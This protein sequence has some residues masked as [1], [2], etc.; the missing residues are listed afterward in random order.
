MTRISAID[1]N[2]DMGESFGNWVMGR[3]EEMFPLITT[4]NIACGFHAGD[5]TVMRRTVRMAKQ[6]GVAVGAHPGYHDLEGFGRRRIQLGPDEVGA[7]L[8]YQIGALRAFLDTEGMPLHHVKPHG[9]LYS[10]LRDD[11]A[12]GLAGA[13][14]I[15]A[16]LPGVM[17]YWPAPAFGTVFCDELRQLGHPVVGDL[18]PD[19]SYD[20]NGTLV[21]K[22]KIT[23]TDMDFAL[24]QVRQFLKSGQVHTEAGTLVDMTAGSIC[25]HG[26]GD[27]AVELAAAV[28]QTVVDAGVA[29]Q[30]VSA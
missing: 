21:I 19:L 5:P 11:E 25:V 28:R 22:R 2:C 10:F 12:A 20:E 29:V 9:A 7:L 18:Y 15:H 16:L 17:I 6:H 13:R 26:D 1:I 27:H 14:A 3:D 8:T 30:A 23:E 4:A 24:G